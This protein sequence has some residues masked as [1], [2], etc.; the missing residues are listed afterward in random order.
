MFFLKYRVFLFGELIIIVSDEWLFIKL[1]KVEF[2]FGGGSYIG[3]RGKGGVGG[4]V[5]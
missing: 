2:R 4:G 1:G 5:L 3:V